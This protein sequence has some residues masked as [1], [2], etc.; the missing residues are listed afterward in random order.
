MKKQPTSNIAREGASAG[1]AAAL[2]RS[3]G[4]VM[5]SLAISA[6]A[7]CKD[8][9]SANTYAPPPPPEVIVANPVQRDVVKYLTYT[10]V[11]EASERVE[12]RARIQGFLEKINFQPGQRVEKGDVLFE[13]DSRQYEAAV[14]QAKANVQAR[15]ATLVGAENDAKLAREMADQRAGSEIDALIKAARRDTF[16][17]EVAEAEAQLIDAT[18]NLEFCRIVAPMDGRITRNYVDIGN[19]VGRGE[20]TLLAEIIQATPAFLTVDVSEADVLEVRRERMASQEEP[21]SAEVEPGQIE[22]GKWRPC[23][24][25]LSD[26]PEFEHKGH[27][28]YVDPKVDPETGTLRVRT[29]Y[30]NLDEVLLPGL[31]SRVRFPM[32]SR[33]ALLVPESALLRDQQGRYALVVN[34]K[35]EV[36][37]KRVEIG[38]LDGSMRVVEKGLEATDRVIVLGVLKARPGAKV[39]PK[40]QQESAAA[41]R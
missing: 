25:A 20:P 41:G 36:E 24:L 38:V 6:I 39:T 18:L 4:L 22:A 2:A 5:L 37:A 13:I 28:D 17:A 8:D 33:Q 16:V 32:S 29:R 3:I 31:F 1:R 19:L 7:G 15:K 40:L 23:E 35:D 27:I 10:G 34:D 12:L 9:G 30:E 14:E 26:R 11:L 21:Q